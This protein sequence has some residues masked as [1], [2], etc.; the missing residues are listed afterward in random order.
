MPSPSK[1]A[2]HPG[3]QASG[4]SQVDAALAL[5]AA[6]EL[7]ATKQIN[8]R[9]GT[10]KGSESNG[11]ST[12]DQRSHYRRPGLLNTNT[13]DKLNNILYVFVKRVLIC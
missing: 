9:R 3:K 8:G 1:Q 10:T 12:V 6:A 13:F 5:G 4:R 2:R 7:E 11:L